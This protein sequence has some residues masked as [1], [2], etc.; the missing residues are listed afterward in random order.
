VPPRLVGL[1]LSDGGHDD[2]GYVPG[3]L[4]SA[5][6]TARRVGSHDRADLSGGGAGTGW[7]IGVLWVLTGH[8]REGKTGVCTRGEPAYVEAEDLSQ[9]SA[10]QLA[11]I[12]N[13]FD[14]MLTSRHRD[15]DLGVAGRRRWSYTAR[16]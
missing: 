8:G 14:R 5:R 10:H 3:A 6:R 15:W 1:A 2:H 4:G 9:L 7:P 13:F 16:G 12:A 11:E